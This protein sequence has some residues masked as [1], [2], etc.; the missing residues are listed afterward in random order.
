[1]MDYQEFVQNG[2]DN[3]VDESDLTP[4]DYSIYTAEWA[5]DMREEYLAGLED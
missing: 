2:I 3:G 5:A 1:M 4:E